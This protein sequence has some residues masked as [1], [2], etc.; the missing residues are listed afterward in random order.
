L[1]IFKKDDGYITLNE[2]L[3]VEMVRQMC[4]EEIKKD[5]RILGDTRA[6]ASVIMKL[7]Q[8]FDF[9]KAPDYLDWK[10]FVRMV[11]MNKMKGFPEE[12][13]QNGMF[14]G[15]MHFMDP[16]NFDLDRVERCC[17]H[18]TTPDLRLIPFCSFNIFHRAEVEKK[19][20]VPLK[21]NADADA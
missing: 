11:I 17:I 14:I 20:S 16:Y 19:Y 7:S 4:L 3:D 18:Y 15:C 12:V 9:D 6:K 2:F 13:K 5:R 21:K 1:Y 10:N 8:A